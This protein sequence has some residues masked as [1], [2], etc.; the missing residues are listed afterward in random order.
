MD[1]L[2]ID[3]LEFELSRCAIVGF[4]TETG[5]K[6]EDE[7]EDEEVLAWGLELEC[8]ERKLFGDRWAP[9]LTC[10]RAFLASPG[11]DQ[12]WRSLFPRVVDLPDEN[13]DEDPTVLMY[14]WS[15]LGVRSNQL[16]LGEARGWELDVEWTARCDVYFDD[17]YDSDL[18]LSVR[19]KA[20]F[21]RILLGRQSEEE[22]RSELEDHLD[23]T[24]LRYTVDDGVAAYVPA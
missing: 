14:L 3:D 21:D 9:K 19:A 7:D 4:L 5:D 1:V 24:E 16:E 18:S 13:D 15:H 17:R 20:R 8:R 23:L 22:A 11:A 10:D 12:S 2:R 6:D